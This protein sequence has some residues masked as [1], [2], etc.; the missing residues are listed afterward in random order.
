MISV[1]LDLALHSARGNLRTTGAPSGSLV[2]I[3]LIC[4]RNLLLDRELNLCNP[5]GC[6]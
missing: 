1:N 3:L 5:H 4:T 6:F 2:L